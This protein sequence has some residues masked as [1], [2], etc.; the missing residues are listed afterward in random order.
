MDNN[1]TTNTALIA[2]IALLVGGIAGYAFGEYRDGSWGR[3]GHMG[4]MYDDRDYRSDDSSSYTRDRDEYGMIGM[5]DHGMHMNMMVTNERDFLLGMIPHHEEAVSTAREV[6][7]RGATTPE[8]QAL[9]EAIVAA[10]EK[11]IADMKNWYRAWYGTEYVATGDYEPMMRDLSRLSGQDLDRVF[12]EDM[13]MHHMGAIMMA[14]SVTP[15]VEHE[16]MKNLTKAIV[17][18]QSQEIDEM[19]RL[20][21]TL[22]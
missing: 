21:D 19:R 20:L 16:E 13:I 15:Y 10:Q 5:M 14:Q 7:A 2:L 22:R 12:L 1:H 8:M 17:N 9:A 4:M 18:T 11:E 6:L 3:F